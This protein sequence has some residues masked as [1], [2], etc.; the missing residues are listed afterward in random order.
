MIEC[1]IAVGSNLDDPARQVRQGFA[2]M[3]RLP[4]TVLVKTSSLYAN[5]PIGPPDQPD[6]INAV[7]CL[8]TDL[9]PDVLLRA[10]KEL[11]QAAGRQAGRIW[12]ER[13]LDLDILTYG[14]LV[15][16]Q[17]RLR[18][19][20]PEIAQRRFVLVPWLEIAPAATLPDGR[21]V[22]GLLA[23]APPHK[24][25]KLTEEEQA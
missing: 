17:D 11:E 16:E 18:I 8:Q 24:L 10:L 1:F 4:D 9:P 12:G 2:A 25:V 13:V 22:A 5:P 7:V 21:A 15:L 23:A 14:D 3:A 20:H 19:P 6:Y